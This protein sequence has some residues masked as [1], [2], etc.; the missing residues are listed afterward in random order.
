MTCPRVEV[1]NEA[2]MKAKSELN[3]AVEAG[4]SVANDELF[5]KS[6]DRSLMW[7]R[8]TLTVKWLQNGTSIYA[9]CLSEILVDGFVAKRDPSRADFFEVVVANTWMYFHIAERLRSVYVV[10]VANL[11]T[12]HSNGEDQIS[13]VQKTNGEAFRNG[14]AEQ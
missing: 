13:S 9:K 2:A 5:M 6:L 10:A 4:K 7:I 8:S 14:V 1:S 12:Y 11:H 3:A